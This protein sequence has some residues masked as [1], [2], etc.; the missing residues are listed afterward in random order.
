[1]GRLGRTTIVHARQSL[2]LTSRSTPC[3]LPQRERAQGRE[4]RVEGVLPVERRRA[5]TRHRVPWD[6]TILTHYRVNHSL[7]KHATD[8]FCSARFF[9]SP[10]Q[11]EKST[12][13]A[14]PAHLPPKA[15]GGIKNK[16]QPR[17]KCLGSKIA[18]LRDKA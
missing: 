11:L 9:L 13:H 5:Y 10:A 14:P 18:T 15:R 4:R 3:E 6:T 2:K 1:M 16:A 17:L 8:G 7:R 12:A